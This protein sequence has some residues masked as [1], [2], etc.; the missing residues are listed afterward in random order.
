MLTDMHIYEICTD[1]Y[2]DVLRMR[3]CM[4]T[5]TPEHARTGAHRPDGRGHEP[6]CRDELSWLLS[7]SLDSKKNESW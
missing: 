6:L 5:Y 1:V 2:A 3:V 7:Y 4:S